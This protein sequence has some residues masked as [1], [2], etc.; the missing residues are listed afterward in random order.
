VLNQHVYAGREH[1]DI[2]T[3]LDCS[4]ATV[5]RRLQAAKAILKKELADRDLFHGPDA[6]RIRK[7]FLKLLGEFLDRHLADEDSTETSE[8]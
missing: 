5:G 1:R 8:E 6:D 4:V 3:D 7:Q 2:A